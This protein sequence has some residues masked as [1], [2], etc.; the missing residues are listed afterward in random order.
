MNNRKRNINRL[1][2]ILI[3]LFITGTTAVSVVGAMGCNG[4]GCD[5]ASWCYNG[6]W[7]K[8]WFKVYVDSPW[9]HGFWGGEIDGIDDKGYYYWDYEEVWIT[10]WSGLLE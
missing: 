4:C 3:A 9:W 6:H 8:R 1:V 5:P 2:A 10:E 7:E